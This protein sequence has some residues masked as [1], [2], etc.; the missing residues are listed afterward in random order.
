MRPLRT[1][2]PIQAG[3]VH[4]THEPMNP[5]NPDK[6]SLHP[7]ALATI[8]GATLLTSH[9]ATAQ[10]TPG[11][12]LNYDAQDTVNSAMGTTWLTTVDDGS[13]NYHFDFSGGSSGV[14]YES[15][16]TGLLGIDNAYR[17]T[18]GTGDTTNSLD[19]FSPNPTSFP[20][21]FEFWIKP[22]DVDTG[23][24][25]VI[26]ESGADGDGC[27]IYYSPGTP[28]DD[29]GTVTWVTKD[30]AYVS[31]SAEI[32]TSEF[33]HIVCILNQDAGGGGID[34]QEIYVDG[35]LVDDNVTAT[36]FDDGSND[37]DDTGQNDWAGGD[38]ARIG[39][40]DSNPADFGTTSDFDGDISIMRAYFNQALT[41]AEVEANYDVYGVPDT[42]A[43]VIE[44]L[45][46]E[47]GGI[48][49]GTDLVATFDEDIALV[50]GG[51]IQLTSGPDSRTITLPNAGVSVAGNVLTIDLSAL[52]G[53]VSN[54][55][56]AFNTAYEVTISGS[57]NAGPDT[58]EDTVAP[59]AYGGTASNQ[60][61]F[62]TVAED[63]T[64]PVIGTY[65][66]ADDAGAVAVDSALTA[67]FDDDLIFGTGNITINR[68]TAPVATFEVFDVTSSS[69]VS[70]VGNQLVIVPTAPFDEAVEYAVQ[71]DSGAVKNFSDVDFGGIA[72]NTTWSFTTQSIYVWIE[73]AG[74]AQSWNTGASWQ[75]GVAP[76]PVSGDGVDFSTADIS[77]TTLTLEADRTAGVWT[78]GDNGGSG[79]NWTVAA[80][81]SMLLA[82]PS[83]TI[84]TLTPTY[85]E[86]VVS[87]SDGFVK[88][89]GA[90]LELR[91]ETNTI[92]GDIAIL[93][94]RLQIGRESND[95]ANT[96]L[97]GGNFTDDIFIAAGSTLDFF[98]NVSSQEFSGVI[99]GD[100]N[101]EFRYS[102]TAILSGA[103]TYTGQTRIRPRFSGRL[104]TL[105][106]SSLNSV[107]SPPQMASSSLGVP[108][109]VNNGTIILGSTGD[110]SSATLRYTGTG[111]TT[112]R[113][114]QFSMNGNG[115]N[116]RVENAGT[117]LLKFTSQATHVGSTS[118]DVQL[119]GSGDGEFDLG[120]PSGPNN[121][122]KIGTGTWTIG[123]T[124]LPRNANISDG[125]LIVSG[126]LDTD[127][128]VTV[129][130]SGTLVGAATG[131]ILDDVSVSSTS[132]MLQID[133][134]NAL[135]TATTISIPND[136]TVTLTLNAD[137]TVA[138]LSIGG[139][140]APYGAYTSA[141]SSFITGAGT[142][143]VGSVAASPVYW[144]IDDTTAGAGGT[145]PAGTWDAITAF[146]NDV[147]GTGTAAAWT[148]GRTA[149]FAAG[150]DAVDP[151]T[152]TVDGT[153]DIGSLFFEEGEVTLSGG[154][155]LRM[156]N[157][158]LAS[159][160]SGLSATVDTP[161][162]EDGT[163][164][165]LIKIG[166]GD[167]TLSGASDF[168]G[169]EMTAG[170][171]QVDGPTDLVTLYFP[172]LA[173]LSVT[174][175]GTLNFGA[176]GLISCN[177][178]RYNQTITNP[179]TGSPNVETRDNGATNQYKGLIFAPDTGTQTLGDVLNPNNTGSTDKAGV[180]LAGSTS[181]NT[182]ASIDYAGGDRYA[183]TN[184]E[185]GEWTVTGNIRTGNVR[186]SGGTHIL[187]GTVDCDYTGF[188]F[189]G[190]TLGGTGTINENVTVPASGGL[191][192]GASAGTLT[193]NGDLD[194]T[195]LAGGGGGQL[196]FELDALAGA[197]DQIAVTG[198]MTIG[199]GA[200]RFSDFTFSNLGGLEVGTYTLM[201][202]T[203]L[204]GTIDAGNASGA[205]GG[206]T[207]TLQ[208]SGNDLVLNVVG[209]GAPTYASWSGGAPAENDANGDGVQNAVAYVL[210]AADVNEVATSLLPTVD[211]SDPDFLI[212]NYRRSDDAEADGTT[213][214]DAEYSN[215]LSG[216]TTAVD[217]ATDLL[218][219]VFN[220]DY[221]T[222]VDRVEVKLRRS[223]F[224]ANDRL[225]IRLRA[226]VTP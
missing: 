115:R 62:T 183:D 97:G 185:S 88:T 134:L 61:T 71:I 52:D 156:V 174:G 211:N 224:E 226:T 209:G 176:G 3:A 225:F 2:S 17:F 102:H 139:S 206:F 153:Q 218:I 168:T 223:V 27:A 46:P 189:T 76:S 69:Q 54:A 80:G 162:T 117:G 126:T 91:N 166:D 15:V 221:D 75:A 60:W 11:F 14:T 41:P 124:S 29:M 30:T 154:T 208:V 63:L 216:W 26:Y 199:A 129:S 161:V 101:I 1:C 151:Y 192:P 143:I 94:G 72:D 85:L 48:Y 19:S 157:D 165:T 100:G 21:T 178:N 198:T 111:E 50:S 5:M 167:L 146:W 132:A 24:N 195:A 119:A 98:S 105:E 171:L 220:D 45:E 6:H 158:A 22:S 67:T 144:D 152:V 200:L 66:P 36:A 78:F 137:Q 28:G 204:G 70:I 33:R 43:P 175:T 99:S 188:F 64:A 145:A 148:A 169:L 164:R 95:G 159:V 202:S 55:D 114:V 163:A 179:I 182:V 77:N 86:N 217:D 12:D 106:A 173:N 57:G 83:P 37:S 177:D 16:T 13:G 201:T 103:N 147:D 128:A 127:N 65:D 170:T 184:L 121:L 42:F 39:S 125:T 109:N 47:G 40:D 222:G 138:S 180:T 213:A 84:D 8:A 90:E 53:G 120:I 31:V 123:G 113:V 93:D 108:S 135:D 136:T 214:I 190:G 212:F 160:A 141:N 59:T 56:L 51:T 87:G 210:G 215:D 20:V 122:E 49:P 203:T 116:Y 150:T 58:I 191:A 131:S 81:N 140:L 187:N 4:P 142:L 25:Q 68:L 197:S 130:G 38:P 35:E 107:S 10:V 74:G 205:I 193:F 181:G 196:E 194:L 110:Q 96:T 79:S 82:G 7:K 112:D 133:A 92:T 34:I 186:L 149:V 9:L 32:D 155:A 89:G 207:G 44:T 18:G 219:T 23:G 172:T 73:G 104:V 118:G